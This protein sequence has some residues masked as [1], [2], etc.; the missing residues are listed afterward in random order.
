M[1]RVLHKDPPIPDNLSHEGKDFLQFCFKRNPAERPTAS[2]LL[3]HP[4]I[5]NSSHYNKHGS[6]HSFAGIKSNVSLCLPD[7]LFATHM[8]M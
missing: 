8:S 3:E 6:I 2:E 5:R 7:K 4:F 1:F